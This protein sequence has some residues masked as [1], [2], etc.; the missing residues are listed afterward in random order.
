[1]S[2][3][4]ETEAVGWR[5]KVHVCM[6]DVPLELDMYGVGCVGWFVEA[7]YVCMDVIIGATPRDSTVSD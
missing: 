4:V 6:L 2:L 1:M 3:W 5:V 7:G